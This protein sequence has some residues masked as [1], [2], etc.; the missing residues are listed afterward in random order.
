MRLLLAR[1]PGRL[2][3]P[4]A[5]I[6]D[7]FITLNREGRNA[8]VSMMIRM[9]RDLHENGRACQFIKPLK[10]FP[11]QEL[12]PKTRGGE[13]GGARVYFWLMEDDAAGIVTCEVKDDD[14]PASQEKI[15][16]TFKVYLA[17]QNGTPVFR[18][19]S[20]VSALTAHDAPRE[21]D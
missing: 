15:K 18:E 11:V 10:G 8:A 19:L 6:E 2:N 4:Y 7:E 12:K 21:T 20:D 17:H 3:A 9:L 1:L 14:A 13:K 16:T 5:I